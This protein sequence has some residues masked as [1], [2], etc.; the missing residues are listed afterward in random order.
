MKRLTVLILT[1]ISS[2]TATSQIDT[3]QADS[4]TCMPDSI[5]RRVI[6]DLERG[7][8]CAI[9]LHI[10]D[11]IIIL[12]EQVTASQD[13]TIQT[14]TTQNNKLADGIKDNNTHIQE[15]DNANRKLKRQCTLFKGTSIIL[16]L[17]LLI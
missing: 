12:Y 2:L 15:L 9:E 17:I 6:K 13:R 16:L 4:I 8:L 7:D 11:S 3:T 1:L 10:A 14:L 5:A